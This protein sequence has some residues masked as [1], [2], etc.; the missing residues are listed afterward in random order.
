MVKSKG[1]IFAALAIALAAW[2]IKGAH[3]WD[4]KA[5]NK[6][7]DETVFTFSEICST[8]LVDAKQGLF[9][10]ANHCVHDMY[11]DVERDV[12]NDKGEVHKKKI[13]VAVPVS[14]TRQE[15]VGPSISRRI[16]Y[17]AAVK[18]A[19]PLH[20]LALVKSK[21]PI[22]QDMSAPI[23]CQEVERGD[24][25][26][27]VGSP[28]VMFYASVSKGVVGSVQRDYESLGIGEEDEFDNA[29]GSNGLVQSTALIAPGSSGG[30]LYNDDGQLVG[31]TVRG[32]MGFTLSV[33]QKDV[34][35]L[36]NENGMSVCGGGPKDDAVKSKDADKSKDED[37]DKDDE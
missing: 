1:L 23:A 34:V 28:F 8:T 10:T 7:V 3:A 32:G 4:K 25:V 11:Q 9:L 17:T 24:T 14:V 21:Q 20:D 5:M 35:D 15:Y 2:P 22:D 18:A 12:V 27:A 19:D 13:R 29:P 6:Q 16:T 26:W 30:A 31:V 37:K 36:L 33:P